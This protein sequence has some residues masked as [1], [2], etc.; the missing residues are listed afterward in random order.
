MGALALIDFDSGRPAHGLGDAGVACLLMSIEARFPLMRLLVRA[1]RAKQ[2]TEELIRQAERLRAEHP[3]PHRL[4]R[5][6]WGLLATS[7]LLRWSGVV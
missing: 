4:G 5:I 1:D 7:L 3:W 6:G 2:S